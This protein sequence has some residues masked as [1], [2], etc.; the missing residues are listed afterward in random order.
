[1]FI[2]KQ[3][4]TLLLSSIIATLATG[5]VGTSS[6]LLT[7]AQSEKRIAIV[8]GNN[9]YTN[10]KPLKTAAN[11]ADDMATNLN[12]LGFKVYHGNNLNCKDMLG[13]LEEVKNEIDTNTTA[14]VYFSG[15]GVGIQGMNIMLP[16]DYKEGG[17]CVS[18]D[19]NEYPGVPVDKFIF[20]LKT[21]GK[22]KEVI[23]ALDMC[24]NNGP[25]SVSKKGATG[26]LQVAQV[27]K[28][29]SKGDIAINSPFN[30][31]HEPIDGIIVG[32]GTSEGNSSQDGDAYGKRNSLYTDA[33][34]RHIN[35]P[36][37]PITEVFNKVAA[38][39][40]KESHGDQIPWATGSQ[41]N[42]FLAKPAMIGSTPSAP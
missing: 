9:E 3:I 6:N 28:G 17:R 13:M 12:K 11:D 20:D 21:E 42:V 34:L 1:M 24:R 23:V 14:F 19:S 31:S 29:I 39:V 8:V 10:A 4:N 7:K 27:T 22:A 32:Y 15:H 26:N 38:E 2:M 36:S 30:P 40:K 35:N 41:V 18:A 16:S 25:E 37:L 5:C 33:L